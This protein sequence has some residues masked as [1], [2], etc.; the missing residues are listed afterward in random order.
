M[1]SRPTRFHPPS[2]RHCRC[3]HVLVLVLPHLPLPLRRRRRGPRRRWR[4]RRWKQRAAVGV[5]RRDV[6]FVFGEADT[7]GAAGP[8][9]LRLLRRAQGR[10]PLPLAVHH[11]RA[12]RYELLRSLP[13][14]SPIG[15]RQF[16]SS[17]KF[18]CAGG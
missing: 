7:E 17:S 1:V 12:P 8:Q 5:E 15:P 9:R 4:R 2:D 18:N 16:E 10:Q 14:A 11:H 13:S 6:G 3:G